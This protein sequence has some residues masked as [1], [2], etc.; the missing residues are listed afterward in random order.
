MRKPKPSTVSDVLRET[1]AE[2]GLPLMALERETGVVRASI[3]RFVRG[4]QTL[5]LSKVDALAE[6]FGLELVKK[7]KA[8]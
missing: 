3:M 6:Y 2:S 1:I 7:R 5:L 8:K 4:D